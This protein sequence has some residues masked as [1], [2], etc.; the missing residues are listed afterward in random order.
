MSLTLEAKKLK[1]GMYRAVLKLNS[2]GGLELPFNYEWKYERKK[3]VMIIHNADERIRVDEISQ[4]GDSL[5]IQMPVFDTEFHCKQTANGMEGFWINNYRTTAQRIAFSSVYGES[6]RFFPSKGLMENVLNG[7]WETTFSPGTATASK[8]LGLFQQV[9]GT[10]LVN[11]TFLTETGDYRYLEG[12]LKDRTLYLSAF[13]GSHAFLFIA[14]V[15]ENKLQGQFYSGAHWKENWEAIRNDHFSLRDAEQLTSIRNPELPFELSM[16]ALDGSTVSLSDERYR[17]KPLIIQLMGSWCPN[18][19]DES[20]YF[21]EVYQLYKNQ[22]LEI[23][24]LAFE[25]TNDPQKVKQQV[26]RLKE[27]LN[28]S[29]VIL[30]PLVSGKDKASE[31]LPRL[32]GITAFPTTLFLNRQHQVVKIHTGFSGPATGADYEVY[33][34]RTENLIKHL[35]Q[36]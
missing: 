27:K 4:Q 29:Y 10:D 23:I 13:D 16:K 14:Q 17:N 30:L 2:S 35:L 28:I 22:G 18:C 26:T 24:A 8:A 12:M 9:E 20:R 5:I 25:K 3:P 21:S 19:M 31:L 7:K 32:S 11:G 36:E 33:K 34:Q 15:T 1:A 6:H